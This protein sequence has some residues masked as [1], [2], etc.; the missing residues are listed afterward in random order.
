MVPLILYVILPL[1]TLSRPFLHPSPLCATQIHPE[2]GLQRERQVQLDAAVLESWTAQVRGVNYVW[3]THRPFLSLEKHALLALGTTP[4]DGVFLLSST[5]R[6]CVCVLAWNGV[7][8]M[9]GRG[10]L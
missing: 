9:T 7:H 3:S 5:T 1:L 10:Q 6:A 4:N 2:L 8:A